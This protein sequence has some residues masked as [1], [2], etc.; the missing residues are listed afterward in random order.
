M[1]QSADDANDEVVKEEEA[2]EEA[3]K[4][5]TEAAGTSTPRKRGGRRKIDPV[6]AEV[7]Y[8]CFVFILSLG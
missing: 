6:V 8:S 5:E 1:V 2:K 3:K 7:S 4:D